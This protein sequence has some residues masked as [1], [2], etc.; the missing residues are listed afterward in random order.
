[1]PSCDNKTWYMQLIQP[2]EPGHEK[3]N[4]V[5]SNQVGHKPGY[6]EARFSCVA[7]LIVYFNM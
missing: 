4:N 7:A 5:V 2:F 3:T 1:M 6:T